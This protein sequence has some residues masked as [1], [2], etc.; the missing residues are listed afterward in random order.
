MK[1][2]KAIYIMLV[3]LLCLAL[4]IAISYAVIANAELADLK[5]GTTEQNSEL[6]VPRGSQSQSSPDQVSES[7]SGDGELNKTDVY[8]MQ[9]VAE[10]F[11]DAYFNYDSSEKEDFLSSFDGLLTPTGRQ[12][13][14]GIS[15]R[16]VPER[17]R[18]VEELIAKQ[19]YVQPQGNENAEAFCMIYSQGGPRDGG[20]DREEEEQYN[21][22][23]LL[24]LLLNLKKVDG[25]W[26][27]NSIEYEYPMGSVPIELGTVFG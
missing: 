25:E 12:N 2:K 9:D 16:Y 14:S 23:S 8:Y 18:F 13:M 19:V 6:V 24:M 7:N 22:K 17:G 27:V 1:T 21:S 26:R 11:L 15:D 5:N 3:V 20:L 4:L 10:R